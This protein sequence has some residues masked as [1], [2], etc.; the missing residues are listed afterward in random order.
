MMLLRPAG[1]TAACALL[2]GED[3]PP[4]PQPTTADQVEALRLLRNLVQSTDEIKQTL[5]YI[6]ERL[7]IARREGGGNGVEV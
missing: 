1:V 2:P 7:S 6:E 3:P 4:L 5:R